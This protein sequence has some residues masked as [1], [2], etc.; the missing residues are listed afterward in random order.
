MAINIQIRDGVIEATFHGKITGEDFQQ[1]TE[2]LSD[3]ESRLEVTQAESR[4]CR[5]LV[6]QN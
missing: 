4:I 5:T 6:F 1:M 2:T 3:L